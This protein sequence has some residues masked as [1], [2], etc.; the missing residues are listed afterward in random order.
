MSEKKEQRSTLTLYLGNEEIEGNFIG[1]PEEIEK[2]ILNT[3]NMDH[4]LKGEGICYGE[5]I[6]I[7][8]SVLHSNLYRLFPEIG[9]DLHTQLEMKAIQEF[10][11]KKE[12]EI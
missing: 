7:P 8:V 1:T 9:S 5:I 11:N 6:S 12:V 3:A 2:I 4:I 10:M